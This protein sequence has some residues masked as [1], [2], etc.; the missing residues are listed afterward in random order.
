[1]L[2]I[3]V[4]VAAGFLYGFVSR[5]RGWV[6]LAGSVLAIY[7]LQSDLAIRYLDFVLP[8]ATLALTLLS[9][10]LVRQSMSTR[11]DG[12]ALA[13]V[14]G[15]VLAVAG[16]RYLVPELRLTSRPPEITSVIAVLLLFVVVG[17]VL[18]RGGRGRYAALTAMILLIVA[19]FAII[20]TGPI[21]AALAGLLRGQV[22]QDVTLASPLDIG[23]LG[24]SY[25]AFRLIHTLRDRQ[26]GRLPDLNLREYVTYVVFFPA[27]TAGPI[28]RAERFV[29]DLRALPALRGW[30]AQRYTV[31]S[32][33]VAVG[34][35][36]KFVV[37]DSL[38]LIALNATSAA[39]AENMA[40]LWLLLY[41][42]AFQLFFDFSGYTDIA[43]G[44]G[45][46][47]GIRLPENFDRPYLKNNIAAFW[48]SWHMTLSAWVRFYVFSPLSRELLRR[49]R[50]PPTDI[51][52]LVSHLSTMI[53]IGLWHGVTVAFFV[54]GLWHGLGLFVHKLWSDRTRKWYI[55]LREK[56][57]LK[58][59]WTLA[60][61][62]LTFHFVVLGWVWFALPDATLGA[63]VL[64]RLFGMGW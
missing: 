25:V 9:W 50:R 20:K 44:T 34:L 24:F 13:L 27:Y 30:D 40:A 6:L 38:A 59:V 64:G 18:W 58:T 8:T 55:G 3:T 7:W 16:T 28:D 23:W 48:Q 29:E 62:V 43:I 4:L 42:Y 26:T 17:L 45:I 19:L 41:A 36:K 35:L 21:S 37:A 61:I 51:I 63:Q 54:W 31:G 47:F 49:K 1:M 33:R 60:G 53:V 46:L 15:L 39:Q 14:I 11:E 57:R 22:G 32:G 10:T 12:A 52:L 56:P 2:E 5:G